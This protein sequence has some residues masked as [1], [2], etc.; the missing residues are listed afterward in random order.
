MLPHFSKNLTR[1]F[2]LSF[3]LALFLVWQGNPLI[4]F[5]RATA[6]QGKRTSITPEEARLKQQAEDERIRQ[7]FQPGRQLLE[8]K[9]VPFEAEALLKED[10]RTKLAPNLAQIPEMHQRRRGG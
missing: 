1:R 5:N 9:G 7:D 10:W 3:T 4:N 2:C 8:Q 6:Q